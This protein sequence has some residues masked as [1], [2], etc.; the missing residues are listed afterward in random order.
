MDGGCARPI[1]RDPHHT[2]TDYAIIYRHFPSRIRRKMRH[3]PKSVKNADA[4]YP[5]ILPFLYFL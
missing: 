2:R 3:F 1:L 4:D 5:G